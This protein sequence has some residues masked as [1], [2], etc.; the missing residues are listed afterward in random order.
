MIHF[1]QT[2][3]TA[4]QVLKDSHICDAIVS[5]LVLRDLRGRIRLFLKPADDRRNQV[6]AALPDLTSELRQKLAPFWGGVLDLDVANSEFASILT[7]V[8]AEAVPIEP[9]VDYPG[10]SIIERHVAKSSWTT[11]IH[12]PPWPLNAHTPPIVAWYSHKGG[13]G[14]STGLCATAMC[15]A[16]AGKR[17]VV[18]DLDLESPGLGTLLSGAPIEHGIIDYLLERLVAG[19][20]FAPNVNDYLTRQNDPQLIGDGGE[21]IVCIP[22]GSVSRWYLEKLARLDYELL[23]IHDPTAPNPLADILQQV[24]REISPD[25]VFIDCRAGLHDLGGLAVHQLSHASILFGLDS[26]QSWDGLR[27]IIRALAQVTPNSPPCLLI[28]AM[29]EATP[30]PRQ[31]EARERFLQKSYDVFCEEFYEEGDVPDIGE[32]GEAHSPLPLPYDSRLAGYQTLGQVAE[33]LQDRPYQELLER[34]RHL[35][36]RAMNNVTAE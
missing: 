16:K 12:R 7:P 34:T 18:V 3:S 30:G 31:R 15:L 11:R 36:A 23:T 35:I 10:W 27:C 21:P 4:R 2:L 14:R 5:V 28:H 19:T 13:V 20:S 33:L 6:A 17:I 9:I 1:E 26:Q 29:E 25:F 22:A 8:R 24:K 32:V